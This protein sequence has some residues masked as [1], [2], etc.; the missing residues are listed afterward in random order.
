MIFIV[1]TIVSTVFLLSLFKAFPRFNVNVFIAIIVNYITA[2][3]TGIVFLEG[4]FQFREIIKEDWVVISVPLGL[5]FITIFYLI[6]QTAQR[7]NLST[8]S[9]ANKMSVAIPVL[10]SVIFLKEHLSPMRI[11]G[12]ILALAAVYLATRGDKNN[13]EH[14]K[15]LWLPVLVFFGSGLIDL[16]INASSAFY[17]NSNEESALFS[18]VTFL[19]AFVCGSIA[20][21]FLIITKRKSLSGIFTG[22]NILGGIILGAPNY[23]SIYF[24]FRAL[25]THIMTSAQLFTLLNL[26]TVLLSALAGRFI[27][28]EKLS[29]TNLLGILTAVGAILLITL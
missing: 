6:S 11:T 9:I 3:V 18:I 27:F 25:D 2:A 23:F 19:A 21:I 10:F 24:L 15:L 12:I 7:I 4:E 16:A 26:S 5:L 22:R 13:P 28:H 8:A 17:L 1:L 20:I 29:F 14:K